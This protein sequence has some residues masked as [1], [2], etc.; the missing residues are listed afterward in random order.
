MEL[1]QA[2]LCS[3]LAAQ[4][5]DALIS[6]PPYLTTGEYSGLDSSVRNWE[7]Q[8]A[9]V[10]GEDGLEVTARLLHDAKRIVRP[11]GWLAVEVDCTR[12]HSAA[13]Q[14]AA[15]GWEDVS[16]HVDLF[17]RERYLLARRSNAS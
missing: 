10:S 14:A 16:V 4:S 6:N 2:D 15:L 1:V 9:L 5:L 13:H 17:G 8:S 7:P 12:G 3:A 11:E